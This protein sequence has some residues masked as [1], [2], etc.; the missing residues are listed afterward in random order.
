MLGQDWFC[1]SCT[2]AATTVG[3]KLIPF[4]YCKGQPLGIRT[5]LVKVGV[6]SKLEIVERMDYIG[7]DHVQLTPEGR[8][9]AAVVTT[10]DDRQD[11]TVFAPAATNKE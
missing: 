2:E 9:V 7:S 5:P 10:Y 6:P 4:H 3:G 1:R 11:C 8:P